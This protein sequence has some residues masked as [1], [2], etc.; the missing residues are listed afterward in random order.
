MRSLTVVAVLVHASLCSS[1]LTSKSHQSYLNGN[2]IRMANQADYAL[3]F[4]CD[5]VIVETEVIQ[6]SYVLYTAAT[7]KHSASEEYSASEE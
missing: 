1:F 2:A 6:S 7:G 3:L 5:G 4:D